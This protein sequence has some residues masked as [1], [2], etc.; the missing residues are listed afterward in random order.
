[1]YSKL[2]NEDQ[3]AG[4]LSHEIGHVLG[5]H[6]S[7]RVTSTKLWQ[8]VAQGG[9]EVGFGGGG[10]VSQFGMSTLL[11]NGRGD[12]LESDDLSVRFMI[13]AGYN[14]NEMIGVMELLK[15]A[16]RASREPKFQ[17]THPD[18]DNRME[19]SRERI[20]KDGGTVE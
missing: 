13:K 7:E 18:P 15:A 17:S 12:E 16:A 20:R 4:I 3:L 5:R 1:L 19:Q 11:N 14:P 8:T 6:S 2:Q 9:A 10:A